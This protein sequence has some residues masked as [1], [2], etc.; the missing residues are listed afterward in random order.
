MSSFSS[1]SSFS[2]EDEVMIRE[3]SA[4]IPMSFSRFVGQDKRRTNQQEES[5]KGFK[6]LK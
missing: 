2:F 1:T 5:N 4:E 6:V 3:S